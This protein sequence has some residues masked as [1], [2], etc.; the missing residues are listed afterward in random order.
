M[1]FDSFDHAMQDQSARPKAIQRGKGKVLESAAGQKKLR[2]AVP[3]RCPHY[4]QGH[5]FV[6]R[7]G[8]KNTLTGLHH[9][10]VL[11]SRDFLQA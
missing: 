5:R 2:K 10:E 7:E 6:G 3:K 4:H 9:N 8:D 11:V 1:L